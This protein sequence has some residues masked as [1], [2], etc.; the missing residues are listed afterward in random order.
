MI[1]TAIEAWFNDMDSTTAAT[2][3]GVYEDSCV[4]ASTYVGYSGDGTFTT[5]NDYIRIDG[6]RVWIQFVVQQGV[7]YPNS[8]H[9]HT[10]RRDKT[11]D[12]GAEF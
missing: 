2:L 3:L 12:Y 8:Y 5:D 10:I 4:L 11:A 6:P 7:A 9:F 1:T